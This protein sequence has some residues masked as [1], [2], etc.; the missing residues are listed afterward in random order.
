VLTIQLG[1]T[2]GAIYGSAALVQAGPL[3]VPAAAAL[4]IV[5]ALVI[6]LVGNGHAYPPGRKKPCW[7]GPETTAGPSSTKTPQPESSN[8]QFALGFPHLPR[9]SQL[10]QQ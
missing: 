1:I 2:I 6:T 9:K 8:R 10:Q 7:R 4:P 5:V 3:M